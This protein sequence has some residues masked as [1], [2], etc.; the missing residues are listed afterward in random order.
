MNLPI[1]LTIFRF[2][3]SLTI[4]PFLI[5]FI[6]PLSNIILSAVLALLLILFALTDFL[7]G[8]YARKYNQVSIL[9]QVLDPLADKCFVLSIFIV[10]VHLDIMHFYAAFLLIAREF[11]VTGLRAAASQQNFVIHVLPLGKWKATVQ[12]CY[13]IFMVFRPWVLHNIYALLFEYAL[14]V[15]M[16]ALSFISAGLYCLSFIKEQNKEQMV[17]DSKKE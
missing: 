4:L 11:I 14:L 13:I 10:F 7:D 17:Q 8:Y 12:Y 15:S 9:G 1:F 3:G 2:I 16:I 5:S 6:I